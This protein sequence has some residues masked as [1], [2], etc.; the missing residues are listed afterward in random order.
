MATL[1]IEHCATGE[2][3]KDPIDGQVRQRENLI[4]ASLSGG[5]ERTAAAEL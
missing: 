2:R 3:A 4:Q 1:K 5:D